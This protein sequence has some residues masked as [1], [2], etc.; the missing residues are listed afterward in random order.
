ML[1]ERRKNKRLDICVIVECKALESSMSSL[2]ITR[3]FAGNGFSFESQD[4]DVE[5]GQSLDF[6]F[7]NA[8][9]NLY[10]S[11]EGEIVWKK[12]NR[13]FGYL[14]GIR[15]NEIDSET[16]RQMYEAVSATGH[17]PLNYFI[18]DNG[19]DEDYADMYYEPADSDDEVDSD[20]DSDERIE[21]E[22]TMLE[23]QLTLDPEDGKNSTA[24]GETMQA[25][26]THTFP[27]NINRRKKKPIY[28]PIVKI[29]ILLLLLLA[30]IFLFGEKDE[31]L[32][33]LPATINQEPV[34][35]EEIKTRQIA[36]T[37]AYVEPLTVDAD[38][39][40]APFFVQ[41]GAWK[42]PE[43]SNEILPRLQELYPDAY[44]VVENNFNIIRIPDIMNREQGWVM[45]EEIA[46]KFNLTGLVIT[47]K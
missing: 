40:E 42:N 10:V 6:K 2:G 21:Q 18:S 17:V 19:D 1:V 31:V 41:V 5:P 29:I 20:P 22:I 47:N 8:E 44:V 34:I 13:E 33:S 26:M 36:Q 3:D 37:V 15:F 35:F 24:R 14:M 16:K 28:E 7:K 25:A 11:A 12:R 27:V 39:P 9:S 46:D 45:L 38:L 23:E 43:Y 30:A 4:F 32:E